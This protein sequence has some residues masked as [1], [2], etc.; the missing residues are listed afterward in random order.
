M[1]LKTATL[2]AILGVGASLLFT[3]VN[4][5][6]FSMMSGGVASLGFAGGLIMEASLLT[7]FIVLHK[8]QKV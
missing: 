4:A 1:S 2:I 6:R 7:F 3:L 8:N 5:V